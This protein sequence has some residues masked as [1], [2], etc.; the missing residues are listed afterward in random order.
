MNEQVLDNVD[1]G[2]DLQS[3]TTAVAG[4][5][6]SGVASTVAQVADPAAGVAQSAQQPTTQ[7]QQR[8]DVVPHAALHEA[9]EQV[10]AL[11]GQIAALEALPRLSTEDAELLKTLRTQ[12]DQPAEPDFLADP[13]GYIDTKLT[14]ALKKL[15]TTEQGVQQTQQQVQQQAQLRELMD[16]V[17]SHERVFTSTT[18]DYPQAL[19]HLRQVRTEQ[20]KL[21]YPQAADAQI[22]QQISREEVAGA[23]QAIQAGLNPAETVYK[24]AKTLGYKAPT[25]PTATTQLGAVADRSAARTLG[26]NGGGDTAP[27]DASETDDALPEFTAA[28]KERFG[29]TRRR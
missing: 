4:D 1:T 5:A 19:A 13:K 16:T 8:Q 24:Y 27:A 26:G 29:V 15:E 3:G 11:K 25:T 17:S 22:A 21:M 9:R 28:L 7:Q 14:R 6:G 18:A 12:R 10:K 2:A 20:L 23:F